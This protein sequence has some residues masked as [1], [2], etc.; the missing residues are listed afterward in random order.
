MKKLFAHLKAA[1]IFLAI[2]LGTFIVSILLSIKYQDTR[3]E[4]FQINKAL[5]LQ[6]VQGLAQ[7]LSHD[8]LRIVDADFYD[9]IMTNTLVHDYIEADLKLFITT[10]F[11]DIR[12]L[13]KPA[14]TEGCTVAADGSTASS[15]GCDETEKRVFSEIFDSGEPRYVVNTSDAD[16]WATYYAPIIS[17]AEVQAVIVI[18]FSMYEQRTILGELAKL[19]DLIESIFTFIIVIVLLVLWFAYFDFRREE[20]KNSLLLELETSNRELNEKTKQ[21]ALETR[22][23]RELFTQASQNLA[24]LNEAQH[25][26][27]VGSFDDRLDQERLLFSDENYRIWDIEPGAAVTRETLLKRIHPEDAM[28]VIRHMDMQDENH[29]DS[30]FSFRI[31][32]PHGGEKHITARV[33]S[34]FDDAGRFIGVRGTHQDISEKVRAEEKEQKQNLLIMHQNR[35]AM[36]GEMLEM[37]AHQWRQPL[38]TLSLTLFSLYVKVATLPGV[39]EG[40]NTLHEKAEHAIQYLSRTI[41]DFKSFFAKDKSTQRFS[42]AALLDETLGIVDNRLERYRIDVH[43]AYDAVTDAQVDSLPSELAQAVLAIVNNAIDALKEVNVDR[44]ISISITSGGDR[45]VRIEIADNAGGIPDEVLPYIF[46][47][48]FSTKKDKNGTG[49]GLYM[50]KMIMEESLGGG[51]SARTEKEQAVFTL[52]L[53]G[54]RPQG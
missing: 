21:L 33:N 51:I 46:D 19:G 24:I 7:N 47:P 10:K 15:R 17:H 18:K 32:T 4:I 34:I 3:N 20:Q 43:K 23:T 11:K 6:Y 48:Y 22:K 26:A 13:V 1:Y 45:G 28:R 12:L 39:P 42:P 37:I 54:S 31:L 9:E 36:Q 30:M 38:N 50:V 49:L 2:A 29:A 44:Q 52:T 27:K 40:I 16:V 35:L 25:I 53:P 14:G 41:D 5:N 8:I